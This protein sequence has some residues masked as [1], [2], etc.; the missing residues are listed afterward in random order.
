MAT[1]QHDPIP[2][3]VRIADHPLH[4]MLIAF[5]I[6]LLMLVPVT[7][8]VFLVTDEIFWARAS[9]WLLLLGVIAACIAA[10]PGLIDFASIGRA[11]SRREGWYHML[12]NVGVLGLA[13]VNLIL[14]IDNVAT[15]V[16]PSGLIVSLVTAGLLM[17]GGWFGWELTF[18]HLVGV[19][20]RTP[21]HREDELTMPSGEPRH[22]P[23]P[24]RLSP[25]A[26]AEQRQRWQ[27]EHPSDEQRPPSH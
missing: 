20:A 16:L 5:P 18:V 23:L 15:S 11:R 13:V 3:R 17:V 2:S 9:Y 10:V 7:D 14:R 27:R 19:S 21:R 22:E 6:V 24:D 12:A 4:P 8:I 26:S 25:G 1:H